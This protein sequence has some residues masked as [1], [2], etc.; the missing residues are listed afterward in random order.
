MPNLHC[1]K[2]FQRFA[3]VTMCVFPLLMGEGA[4]RAGEGC[5]ARR[6]LCQ[7]SKDFEGSGNGC[8]A[9][10]NLCQYSR[11]LKKIVSWGFY[12]NK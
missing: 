9:R 1:P 7:Y 8:Y 10:R 4:R 2:V 11:D 3:Q 6:D 12:P 5:Y